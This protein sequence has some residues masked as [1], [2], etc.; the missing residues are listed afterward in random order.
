MLERALLQPLGDRHYVGLLDGAVVFVAQQ[1]LQQHLHG[2]GEL[3]NSLQ[4][5]LLGGGQA[6]I[7][8]GLAT[9]LEG[10]PAFE[11]VERGHVRQSQL[12]VIPSKGI[13]TPSARRGL[14]ACSGGLC[15]ASTSGLYN[16]S[17]TTSTPPMV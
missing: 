7:N 8:V 16:L 15:A 9:D 3:G 1:I 6:V 2:I 17:R 10:L 5:V 11:A 13:K 4:T 12:S 14:M